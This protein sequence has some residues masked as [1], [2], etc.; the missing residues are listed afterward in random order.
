MRYAYK[1]NR[2]HSSNVKNKKR[3]MEISL[4]A[5]T[6]TFVDN[7]TKECN[8]VDVFCLNGSLDAFAR[9]MKMAM[10]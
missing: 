6:T 5:K 9:H 1:R 8:S 4:G 2:E 7:H 3:E 10:F